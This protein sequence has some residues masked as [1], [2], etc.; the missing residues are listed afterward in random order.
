M[1]KYK[2][3]PP[4]SMTPLFVTSDKG[5]KKTSN[6]IKKSLSLSARTSSSI[7]SSR[8]CSVSCSSPY[9]AA[10]WSS[11]HPYHFVIWPIYS[12]IYPQLKTIKPRTESLN[13]SIQISYKLVCNHSVNKLCLLRRKKTYVRC[14]LVF[15]GKCPQIT[16]NLT[17]NFLKMPLN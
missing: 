15:M 3:T 1:S 13:D 12:S 17:H 4:T 10:S 7:H 2:P 8:F 11:A 5:A 16:F 14:T 9:H 6:A